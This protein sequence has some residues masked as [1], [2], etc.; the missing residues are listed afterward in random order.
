MTDLEKANI[1]LACLIEAVKLKQA[2]I[3]DER[4][5]DVVEIAKKLATFVLGD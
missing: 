3:D 4:K 2:R 5:N 1:R